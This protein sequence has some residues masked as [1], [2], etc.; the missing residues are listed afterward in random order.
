MTTKDEW[1]D[2]A[3]NVPGAIC[4]KC[5]KQRAV[6]GHDPCLG[7]LSGV[8]YACCG[9]GRAGFGYIYFESGQCIRMK[10]SEIEYY[11]SVSRPNREA[12]Q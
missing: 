8:Q 11:P 12:G 3:A 7:Q 1:N 6:D 10:V 9:H 2:W 5:K 4:P